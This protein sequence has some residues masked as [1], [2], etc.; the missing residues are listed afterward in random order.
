MA[1]LAVLTHL[2]LL[3]LRRGLAEDAEHEGVLDEVVDAKGGRADGTEHLRL[4]QIHLQE[5]L[6][7]EA[8]EVGAG[9][10]AHGVLHALVGEGVQQR[11]PE[12]HRV[13]RR[14]VLVFLHTRDEGCLVGLDGGG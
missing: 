5:P 1:P 7:V 12:T 10:G 9:I 11:V 6:Q 14:L 13:Q 3:F 4:P 2:D 8:V